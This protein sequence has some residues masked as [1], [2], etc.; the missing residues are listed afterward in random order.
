MNRRTYLTAAV[1]TSLGLGGCLGGRGD[2]TAT[3][4]GVASSATE[5]DA[6]ATETPAPTDAEPTATVA[7]AEREMD[8]VLF[9]ETDGERTVTL[10]LTTAGETLLDTET[11]VPSGGH[12]DVP[13]GVETEGEYELAA[14][15]DTGLET[16]YRFGVDG[17]DLRTG[18]NVAVWIAD[19]LTVGI[20]E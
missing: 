18:S 3:A 12:T 16:T 11:T 7:A 6:T 13:L 5:T 20:E 8:A 19:E 10:E 2:A 15:V 1:V 9:N 4:T 17:Y 14:S